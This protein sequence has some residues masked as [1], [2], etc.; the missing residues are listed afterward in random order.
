[1][2]LLSEIRKWA[3]KNPKRIVLPEEDDERVIKAKDYIAKEGIA[4]IVS[5]KEEAFPGNKLYAAATMVKSGMADGFVAGAAH[6]TSD[7]AKAAL[8]CIGVDRALKVMSGAF[9][10]EVPSSAYGHKGAFIFSDCGIVP[11]PTAEQLTGI[12]ISAARFAEK[13]LNVKP[14]VAMLSYST[15]GSAAT[16]DLGV[17]RGAVESV[18]ES[19]PDIE[20]DGELQVDAA[21]DPETAKVK[22]SLSGSGVAG[23]ANVLIFPNLDSGNIAYKLIQRLAGA[24]AVGPVLLGLEKPCSDLSRACTVDDVIDAVAITSVISQ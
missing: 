23:K 11:F 15:K 5:L 14:R 1:M 3:K 8:K 2:S 13:I 24:R 17:I 12:A 18:K 22:H 7:V 16:P 6:K 20:I 21:L 10:I 19:C 4:E 9:V